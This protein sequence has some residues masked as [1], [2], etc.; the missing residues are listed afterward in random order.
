MTQDQLIRAIDRLF[1]ACGLV[2]SSLFIF[3][4]GFLFL[5]FMFGA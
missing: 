3:G 1:F 4:L 2:I 5:Y